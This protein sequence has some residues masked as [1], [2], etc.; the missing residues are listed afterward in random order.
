LQGVDVIIK[1]AAKISKINFRL[2]GNG[3]TR[4]QSEDLAKSLR[5]RNIEFIDWISLHKLAVELNKSKII[6]GIFGRG[7]K[8][9]S[10][11]PNKVYDAL[12]TR[13][14]IISSD[15]QAA[16]ELLNDS[17]AILIEPDDGLVLAQAIMN[18]MGNE[19]KMQKMAQNGYKLFAKRLKPDKVVKNVISKINEK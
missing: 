13:K 11:I 12:A 2:I 5:L 10:V 16:R 3:K 7:I 15:T 4:K 1:A 8:A 17:N 14:P 6:L 9:Q 19:P 18:L